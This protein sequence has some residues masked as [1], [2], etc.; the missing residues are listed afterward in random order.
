VI[1]CKNGHANP[2]GTTYCSVCK[3]YIDAAT[4]PPAPPPPP[5]PEPPPAA[6]VVTLSQTAL[7]VTAGSDVEGEVQIQNPGGVA[8]DYIVEVVGEARPWTL[9]EPWTLS[10]PAGATGAAHII[11]RPDET[12]T[13]GSVPF[14]VKVTAKTLPDAPVVVAG[15]V[16][17]APRPAPPQP[18]PQPTLP[19]SP[20]PP[21]PPPAVPAPP[22]PLQAKRAAP[23]RNIVVWYV[24]GILT[25]GIGFLVWYYKINKDAKTLARDKGWSPALS[26]F[27]V[28]VG[29]LLIIPPLVSIWRTW[30][31]VRNATNA[32]GMS[33][34]IQFCFCFIPLLNIAYSGYLQSKLNRAVEEQADAAFLAEAR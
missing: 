9:V 8:D 34:G 20:P 6:P 18:Q 31:R 1:L 28:T 22:R 17:V 19:A 29:A 25:L 11:F 26:V 2:E 21:V 23:T 33:A 7:S 14:E 32:D 16:E 13:G 12:S 27:A 24:V 10:V 30:T 5:P 4:A 15:R 3:V